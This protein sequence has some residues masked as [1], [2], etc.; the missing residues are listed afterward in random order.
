VV[1]EFKILTVMGYEECLKVTQKAKKVRNNGG[2]M[3][4]LLLKNSARCKE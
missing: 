4:F 1:K 2:N 3:M